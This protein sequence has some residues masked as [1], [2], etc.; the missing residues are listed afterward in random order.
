MV[1][2]ATPATTHSVI[3]G[4]DPVFSL[5]GREASQRRTNPNRA[6]VGVPDN[7]LAVV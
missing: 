7:D 6:I 4:I 2:A 5:I 3:A 1:T